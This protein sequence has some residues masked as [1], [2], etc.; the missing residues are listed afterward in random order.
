[1]RRTKERNR[2]MNS[3]YEMSRE[4]LEQ[5]KNAKF[6][7]LKTAREKIKPQVEQIIGAACVNEYTLESM[8]FD[9]KYFH[10]HNSASVESGRMEIELCFR[11]PWGCEDGRRRLELNVCAAGGFD[12]T[13]KELV[14]YY[15]AVGIIAGRL[16]EMTDK[17]NAIAE[18]KEF[19]EAR[20]DFADA[21]NKIMRF[22]LEESEREEEERKAEVLAKLAVGSEIITG[23][24][25]LHD[26]DNGGKRK[27][28]GFTKAKV[29]RMTRKLIWLEGVYG[30]YKIDDVAKLLIRGLKEGGWSFA[31]EVDEKDFAI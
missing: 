9:F 16:G 25:W 19:D 10:L 14:A 21:K 5:E 30:R 4:T 31:A 29:E 26:W 24:K 15:S 28:N 23:I 12:S 6:E 7:A 11:R 3:N 27:F 8:D 17:L 18:W 22:D 13:R 1:M 2:K 20:R